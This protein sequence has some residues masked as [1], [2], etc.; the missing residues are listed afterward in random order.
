[1]LALDEFA[2]SNGAASLGA[3]EAEA[4]Q[5][6]LSQRAEAEVKEFASMAQTPLKADEQ[7][8]RT[9]G[10]KEWREQRGELGAN[11]EARAKALKCSE[12]GINSQGVKLDIQTTTSSIDSQAASDAPQVHQT[13]TVP[14]GFEFLQIYCRW[15]DQGWG[16]SK[17]RLIVVVKR[18]S[19]N[20]CEHDCFGT[21]DHEFE[22]K[23]TTLP[24]SEL[25]NPRKGDILSIQ[26]V[27]GGGG[28]HRLVIEELKISVASGKAT[29]STASAG[30][31]AAAA[32][33]GGYPACA[34]PAAPA[35]PAGLSKA[36]TQALVKKVF[37]ELVAEGV[38]PNEA[39]AKA[40]ERAKKE[41]LQALTKAAFAELVASGMAPNDAA[42][43]AVL[44]A[45][46]QMK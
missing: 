35:A 16:L 15:K 39:V 19:E 30:P 20:L 44:K 18:G 23:S 25:K 10:D 1:M 22:N 12:T 42:A 28:G 37:A 43:K 17:G 36:D 32:A 45:K 21:A 2:L 33:S 31:S 26:Y 46:E 9:S 7:V 3:P 13:L 6:A 41:Q 11:A 24:A 34:T 29:E 38:P 4:R 27:V 40:I 8:G 5:A 14:D